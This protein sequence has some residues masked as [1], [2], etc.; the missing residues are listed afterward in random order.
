MKNKPLLHCPGRSALRILRIG[1]PLILLEGIAVLLGYLSDRR[2]DPVWA[3][4]R[5]ATSL[6]DLLA[7][8]I[9]L[10]G[11]GILADAIEIDLKKRQ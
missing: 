7:A 4:D 9:L 6:S 11:L 3:N 1:L 10:I 8:V 5:W 2:I